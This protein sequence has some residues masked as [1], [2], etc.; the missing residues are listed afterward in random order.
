VEA[1]IYRKKIEAA[2]FDATRAGMKPDECI[3]EAISAGAL[4]LVGNRSVEIR[5]LDH[6]DLARDAWERIRNGVAAVHEMKNFEQ[7][8]KQVV[9]VVTR[10][11]TTVA[12][13]FWERTAQEK[14]A[15]R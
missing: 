4:S 14:T 1:G 15:A 5:G 12:L 9:A 3:R 8:S 13:E 10:C 2:Y 11:L 7:R 6:G